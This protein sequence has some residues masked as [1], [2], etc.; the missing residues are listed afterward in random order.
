MKQELRNKI[1]AIIFEEGLTVYDYDQLNDHLTIYENCH[2]A[3]W[4]EFFEQS[5]HRPTEWQAK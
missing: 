3:E 2:P 1:R 4:F 5:K